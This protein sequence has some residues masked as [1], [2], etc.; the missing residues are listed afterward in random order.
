MMQTSFFDI[1][2]YRMP[3]SLS[4]KARRDAGMA[5]VRDN[6]NDWAVNVFCRVTDFLRY[7]G[8]DIVT[9]EDMRNWC[10]MYGVP[11]PKHPNA[12][13]S[14]FGSAVRKALKNGYITEAGTALAKRPDAHGRLLRAYRRAPE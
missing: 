14:V 6:N 7:A 13:S 3:R 1:P 2:E 8:G 10:N 12:W 4:G 5:K 11:N 9:A